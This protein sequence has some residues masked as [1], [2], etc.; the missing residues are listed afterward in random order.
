[1]TA[2]APHRPPADLAVFQLQV[3]GVGRRL[4]PELIGLALIL[5]LAAIMALLLMMRGDAVLDY[6]SELN[7]LVP[8]GA[9]LLPF[10]LWSGER[11]FEGSD[12]WLLPVE[13]QKHVLIRV[14]AGGVWITAIIAIVVVTFNLIALASSS[15]TIAETYPG[16]AAAAPRAWLWFVPLGSGLAAYLLAS[17]LNL[18]LRRPLLWSAGLIAAGLLFS[19]LWF[20]KLVDSTIQAIVHGDL[21]L[22]RVLTG[23]P[24]GAAWAV[25]VLFWLGLALTA[26]AL[27]SLRHRER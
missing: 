3:R 10:R 15:P 4:R 11:L 23:G 21:G 26:V 19:V 7:A 8:I 27:A 1:M 14:A 17:A 12:L 5:N 9:F 13:R 18:A 22:D 6:P 2:V 20:G 24:S 25:A 16:A